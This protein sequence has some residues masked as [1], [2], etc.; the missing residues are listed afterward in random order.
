MDTENEVDCVVTITPKLL[1]SPSTIATETNLGLSRTGL[2][3]ALHS[4]KHQAPQQRG[5]IGNWAIKIPKQGAADFK[6]LN[7]DQI[8]NLVMVISFETQ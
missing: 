4:A 1:E 7:S 8:N 5:D 3:V 2:H 6:S